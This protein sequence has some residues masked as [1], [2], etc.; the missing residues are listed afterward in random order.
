MISTNCIAVTGSIDK[1]FPNSSIDIIRNKSNT[2]IV[3]IDDANHN[4]ETVISTAKNLEILQQ[5]VKLCE[6]FV[7]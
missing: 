1:A 2:E 7:S 5:I 3:I 6:D 4:L